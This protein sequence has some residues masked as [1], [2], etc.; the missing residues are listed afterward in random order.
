[1]NLPNSTSPIKRNGGKHPVCRRYGNTTLPI[2]APKRPNIITRDMVI[3]LLL[4]LFVN[5][6]VSVVKELDW[7]HC[8]GAVEWNL[9]NIFTDIWYYWMLFISTE[10]WTRL[11]NFFWLSAVS[12]VPRIPWHPRQSDRVNEGQSDKFQYI[13][14]GHHS[15]W[16]TEWL[17]D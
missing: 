6:G 10:T 8:H 13:G 2:N 16:L 11:N 4:Y 1:M 15:F 9:N 12:F 14:R 5:K 17:S 3:V 7:T